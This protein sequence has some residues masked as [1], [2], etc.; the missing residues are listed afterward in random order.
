[1]ES[2]RTRFKGQYF[3]PGINQVALLKILLRIMQALNT[4]C[5]NQGLPNPN[6]VL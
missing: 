3:L 2:L 4:N 1:M 5:T 6:Q